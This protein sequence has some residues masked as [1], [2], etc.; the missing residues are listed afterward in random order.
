[1]RVK[2]DIDRSFGFTRAPC[3]RPA[4]INADFIANFHEQGHLHREAGF[5][6]RGLVT[7]EEAVSPLK[8]GSVWVTSSTTKFGGSTEKG[9]P[10]KK[11]TVTLVFSFT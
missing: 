7:F 1:M 5:H 3:I 10:L 9:A 11:R 4:R 6:R 8:P 2:S